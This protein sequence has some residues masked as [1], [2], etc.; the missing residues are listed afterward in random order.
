MQVN[1]QIAHNLFYFSTQLK[2]TLANL[3]DTNLR[4]GLFNFFGG[5]AKT[6]ELKIELNATP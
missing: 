4:L 3:N 1:L 2:D 6:Q 5:G